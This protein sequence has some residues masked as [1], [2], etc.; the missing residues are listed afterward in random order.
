MEEVSFG[1]IAKLDCGEGNVKVPVFNLCVLG[2]IC[3]WA[4]ERCTPNHSHS[5]KRYLF[6]FI[7]Y[8]SKC[9]GFL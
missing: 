2:G 9:G 4:I 3:F 5:Q 8:Q 1:G 6:N 7:A